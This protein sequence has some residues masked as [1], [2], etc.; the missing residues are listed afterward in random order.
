MLA[1]TDTIIHTFLAQCMPWLRATR[2]KT[3]PIY[4]EYK[5]ESYAI[6]YNPFSTVSRVKRDTC[7]GQCI[8]YNLSVN[9]KVIFERIFQTFPRRAP[10]FSILMFQRLFPLSFFPD[11]S[12]SILSMIR[13]FLFSKDLESGLIF[14]NKRDQSRYIFFRRRRI[15]N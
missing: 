14:S 4:Y 3:F 2:R 10:L 15:F 5:N 9:D 13:N 1:A 12:R 8:N 7:R 6:V 11:I